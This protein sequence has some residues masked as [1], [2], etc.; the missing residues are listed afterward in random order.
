MAFSLFCNP[1]QTV[2]QSFRVFVKI[3]AAVSPAS[4]NACDILLIRAG[5][6]RQLLIK[7]A[8]WYAAW[9]W[10]GRLQL[11]HLCFR[12]FYS[13]FSRLAV[14]SFIQVLHALQFTSIKAFGSSSCRWKRFNSRKA[15]GMYF[16]KVSG[17]LAQAGKIPAGDKVNRFIKA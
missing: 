9:R 2:P 12:Q 16:M 10:L 6:Y 11:L 5:I 1:W 15:A 17:E 7:Q 3:L 8:N 13:L 14:C 4:Y